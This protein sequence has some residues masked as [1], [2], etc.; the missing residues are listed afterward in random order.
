M[1]YNCSSCNYQPTSGYSSKSAGRASYSTNTASF[2]IKGA[3]NR[4]CMA[5]GKCTCQ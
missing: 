2:I 3:C 5:I 1:N 4:I